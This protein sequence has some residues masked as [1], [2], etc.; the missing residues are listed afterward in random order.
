MTSDDAEKPELYSLGSKRPSGSE[1]HPAEDNICIFMILGP[2]QG[3]RGARN[4]NAPG[5]LWPSGLFFSGLLLLL[6]VPC[7]L[8][9]L[10]SFEIRANDLSP[11]NFPYGRFTV[12]RKLGCFLR[13][14]S[15]TSVDTRAEIFCH[16]TT[17]LGQLISFEGSGATSE[18]S[19]L[20]PPAL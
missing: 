16:Q 8:V 20:P 13:S 2:Q 7:N 19:V 10:P 17:C 5:T 15:S 1:T 6:F 4:H 12:R 9:R 18:S 11:V 14:L 3:R